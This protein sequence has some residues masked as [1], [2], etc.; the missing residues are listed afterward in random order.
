MR[1]GSMHKQTDANTVCQR[2]CDIVLELWQ[3]TPG[4]W[5]SIR[6]VKGR[7][8]FL[9][10]CVAHFPTHDPHTTAKSLCCLSSYLPNFLP[11]SGNKRTPELGLLEPTSHHHL[12]LLPV[13]AARS[14]F[15]LRQDG[16]NLPLPRPPLPCS[17]S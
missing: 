17:T 13:V 10:L 15:L 12:L 11:S 16:S 5:S 14:A 1:I 9:N 4:T 7:S 6:S 2:P 8:D 3:A